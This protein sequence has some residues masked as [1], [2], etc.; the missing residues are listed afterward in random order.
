MESR[1]AVISIIVEN[2]DSVECLNRILHEYGIYIIG[3]MGIPY[4]ERGV[5]II[6]VAIDAPLDVINALTG[7][8]GR[9]NGISAKAV[10]SNAQI[11]EAADLRGKKHADRETGQDSGRKKY[12]ASGT[13]RASDNG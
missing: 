11:S 1:I 8:I 13:G 7:K 3:R 10:C 12:S 2:S 9:L 5:N 4:R 6:S